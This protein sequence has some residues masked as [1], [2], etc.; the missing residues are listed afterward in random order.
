M[1]MFINLENL[2]IAR[3]NA[4]YITPEATKTVCGRIKANRVEQCGN[5]QAIKAIY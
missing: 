5:H 1:T 3:E 4:G 2:K